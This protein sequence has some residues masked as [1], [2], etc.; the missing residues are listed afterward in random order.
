M[1][2]AITSSLGSLDAECIDSH[3]AS[4][5]D[6]LWMT[7]HVHHQNAVSMQSV[8]HLLGGHSD[9][10]HEQFAGLCLGDHIDELVQFPL[11][12]VIVCLPRGAA[13]LSQR[14][15]HSETRIFVQQVFF[16][17]LDRQP[18][19]MQKSIWILLQKSPTPHTVCH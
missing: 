7:D 10:G 11:L 4:L 6:V 12:V 1:N 18:G 14:K 19:S 2:V 13:H 15:V 9:G 8:H 17:L 16:D 5:L 3:I